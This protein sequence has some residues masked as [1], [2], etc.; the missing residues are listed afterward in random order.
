MARDAI[1]VQLPTQDGTQ[2]VEVISVTKQAVTQANGIKISNAL[3][4]KNNSLQISIENTYTVSSTATA[5]AA[6]IKAGNKYPNKMLGDLTVTLGAAKTTVVILDD[7]ARFENSDGSV[8][9][10]FASGF[11]GNI[12]ATAKRAG[13]VPAS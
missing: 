5:S 11:T 8:C 12:W 2:S 3:A 10:D 1:T 6:T 7:I 9:I 13:L 4:N